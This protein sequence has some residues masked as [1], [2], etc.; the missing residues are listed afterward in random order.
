MYFCVFSFA[1][2]GFV[3]RGGRSIWREGDWRRKTSV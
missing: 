1:D 2:F 3:G